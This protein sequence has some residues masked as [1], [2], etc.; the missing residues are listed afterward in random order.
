MK[1]NE[2]SQ[3]QIFSR[4]ELKAIRGGDGYY[5]DVDGYMACRDSNQDLLA[6]IN[7]TNCDVENWDYYCQNYGSYDK[8]KSNCNVIGS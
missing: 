4:D 3:S 6:G 7:V 1:L 5:G 8:N 2:I